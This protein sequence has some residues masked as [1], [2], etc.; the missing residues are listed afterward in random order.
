VNKL[1]LENLVCPKCKNFLY[2]KND[3]FACKICCKEYVYRDGKIYFSNLNEADII[4]SLDKLK[5]ILKKF[6][7]FYYFLI[8]L[9][10]PV[11]V[12]GQVKK[13]IKQNLSEDNNSIFINLGSGNSN[14]NNK[15]LNV[16]IFD[17]DNVNIV[18]DISTL[19]FADNSVDNIINIAVLEHVSDP[20]II[21]KEIK[22]VLKPG[23]KI[24]CFFPFI[25]AFHASPY[26]FTR[27]TSE[28]IK[29]LFKDFKIESIKVSGGPASG[30]LWILQDFLA[31]LFSFGSKK[32]F[33]VFQLFFMLVLFPIKFLDI[34]LRFHPMAKNI[35]S[36]FL[37]IGEKNDTI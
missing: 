30:F 9:I 16:D 27:V 8:Y 5:Y 29:E 22:R 14:V 13:F 23:G 21:V 32:L 26:D 4:D 36:G 2:K 11:Y 25:Q 37:L 20:K 28:G 6:S 3:K 24:C 34:I 18:C 33:S 35:S 7:K 10:S 17:Y 1:I 19:P 31:I 12:D 15:I